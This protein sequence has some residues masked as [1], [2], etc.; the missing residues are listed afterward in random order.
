MI[1]WIWMFESFLQCRVSPSHLT[2]NILWRPCFWKQK[3]FFSP[4]GGNPCARGA[5]WWVSPFP[6]SPSPSLG[7]E[8]VGPS[9]VGSGWV[10]PIPI[11]LFLPV[12]PS[13]L[14]AQKERYV[15]GGGGG[16]KGKFNYMQFLSY[17]SLPSANSP[18]IVFEPRWMERGGGLGFAKSFCSDS[19]V[20]FSGLT[21][22]WFRCLFLLFPSP[23]LFVAFG[24]SQSNFHVECAN[25]PIPP[26]RCF[27]EAK[28]E[29][30]Y[31]YLYG[32]RRQ[33]KL[34]SKI[35]NSGE[36]LLF[37]LFP[38]FEKTSDL[39]MGGRRCLFPPPST[40]RYWLPITR[41]FLP[42]KKE[43]KIIRGRGGPCCR[44]CSPPPFPFLFFWSIL[45]RVNPSRGKQERDLSLI[46]CVEY[47]HTF[48]QTN[49]SWCTAIKTSIYKTSLEKDR[50]EIDPPILRQSFCLNTP[51]S[52]QSFPFTHP[53]QDKVFPL[54]HPF[55]NKVFPLH[56]PKNCTWVIQSGPPTPTTTTRRRTT[57]SSLW[58]DGFD[59]DKKEERRAVW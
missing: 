42:R 45:L 14:S 10:G 34:I 57:S 29:F 58:S 19:G 31:I 56:T 55:Q 50:N 46:C 41:V 49:G 27:Y 22:F 47:S 52:K 43:K 59:A 1:V 44:I 15:V 21:L 20:F 2:I 3:N 6:P 54:T 25:S 17:S 48:W 36:G 40:S 30:P 53:F 33:A 16:E 12:S 24:R 38:P 51:I 11:S 7:M 26:R 37:L 13:L 35:L 23:S 32:N 39:P 28:G 8:E 4:K 5:G 9:R 18:Q